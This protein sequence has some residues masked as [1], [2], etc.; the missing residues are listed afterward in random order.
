MVQ[1][2]FNESQPIL[3]I[4]AVISGVMFIAVAER[5]LGAKAEFKRTEIQARYSLESCS[6]PPDREIEARAMHRLRQPRRSKLL[7]ATWDSR[8]RGRHCLLVS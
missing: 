1:R 8:G 4:V 3:T 5:Q 7:R 6:L 2:V